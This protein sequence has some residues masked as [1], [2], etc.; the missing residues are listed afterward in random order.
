MNL[1]NSNNLHDLRAW[2]I[3]NKMNIDEFEKGAEITRVKPVV[4]NYQSFGLM[5]G[6]ITHDYQ[7]VGKKL[8]FITIANGMIYAKHLTPTLE[9]NRVVELYYEKYK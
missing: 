6:G 5:G 1:K 3:F 4:E 9:D 8:K 7:Y 2:A